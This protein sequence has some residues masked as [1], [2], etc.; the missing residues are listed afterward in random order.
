MISP[1]EMV[2]VLK[3]EGDDLRGLIDVLVRA[4]VVTRAEGRTPLIEVKGKRYDILNAG[5]L[6]FQLGYETPLQPHHETLVEPFFKARQ[7]GYGRTAYNLAQ[8]A[9][10]SALARNPFRLKAMVDCWRRVAL[11]GQRE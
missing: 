11:D 6:A 7:H 2:P 1:D 10:Q 3:L 4:Q 5:K 9:H 8:R